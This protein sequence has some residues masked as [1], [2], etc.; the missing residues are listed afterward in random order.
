M[1]SDEDRFKQLKIDCK[2]IK[3]HIIRKSAEQAI[4]GLCH[5]VKVNALRLAT[6]DRW[7]E[8][9]YDEVNMVHEL[10]TNQKELRK[11]VTTYLMN[12]VAARINSK[13]IDDVCE[14]LREL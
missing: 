14:A 9:V 7:C 8:L 4:V 10:L 13:V 3:R 1:E 2:L 12:K 6:R 5:R 11:C